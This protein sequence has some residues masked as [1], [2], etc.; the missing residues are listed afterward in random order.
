MGD[1]WVSSQGAHLTLD[2]GAF[3]TKWIRD[4]YDEQSLNSASEGGCAA[5]IVPRYDSPRGCGAPPWAIAAIV[6]PYNLYRYQGD[7]RIVSSYYAGMRWFMDWL[8]VMVY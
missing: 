7:V 8:Q 5:N 4:I 1:A 6:V 2:M 3:Y